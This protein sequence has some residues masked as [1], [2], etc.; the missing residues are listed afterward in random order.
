MKLPDPT[1]RSRTTLLSLALLTLAA[2]SRDEVR[3][4]RIP[5]E[6]SPQGLPAGHPPMPMEAGPATPSAAMPPAPPSGSGLSW[7]LPQ[8]WTQEQGGGMR[9]ATLKTGIPGRIDA[10]VIMLAGAAGG[11]LANVNRWRSQIGLAPIDETTMATQRTLVKSPAGN[12][13]VFDFSGEGASASR[14][15]AGLITTSDGNTWFF[16]VTGDVQPVGKAKPS[17]LRL[18]ESLRLD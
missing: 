2:C 18:L 5:K 11:E 1:R 8:G 10:S 7:K 17:L 13:S 3:H 9:F 14:T 4:Y 6:A 15:L 12:V 16:K